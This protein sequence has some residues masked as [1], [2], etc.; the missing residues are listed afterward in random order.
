MGVEVV[1]ESIAL[2][3]TG[4]MN[5]RMLGPTAQVTWRQGKSWFP[6]LMTCRTAYHGCIANFLDGIFLVG[7][8]VDGTVIAD[9]VHLLAFPSNLGDS[10]ALG[11]LELLNELVDDIDKD[12]LQ[13]RSL[14]NTLRHYF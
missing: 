5:L 10:V 9:G 7:L 2:A 14:A 13:D 6:S 11:L 3:M 1:R 8:G 12:N 4:A